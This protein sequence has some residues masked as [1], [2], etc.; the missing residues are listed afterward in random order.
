M[1][2]SE[3]E[4]EFKA[5]YDSGWSDRRIAKDLQ[6]APSKVRQWRERN[7]LLPHCRPRPKKIDDARAIEM[8]KLGKSDGAIAKVM[9]VTKSGVLKWRQRRGFDAGVGA[10]AKIPV[11]DRR[12]AMKLLRQGLTAKDAGIRVGW[13]KGS[14]RKLRRQMDDAGL[15]K[16]GVTNR[17]IRGQVLG[18]ADL[19]ER[20]AQAVGT[21]CPAHIREEAVADL[22]L[23]VLS[24]EV[25]TD[26]IEARAANFRGK[27]WEMCG[28]AFGAVSLD[29]EDENGLRMIDQ[30]ADPSSYQEDD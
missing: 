22:Y 11:A 7:A 5:R 6:T 16:T 30:I 14:M 3:Q 29:K 8:L 10:P 28:S 15:R 1:I 24:G 26:Q 19:M 12:A 21:Q 27:A 9:G 2:Q 18:Q 20:I 23:A 13:S 4:I 25:A 17:A